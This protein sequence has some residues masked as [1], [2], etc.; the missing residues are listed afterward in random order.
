MRKEKLNYY[1][2]D[3]KAVKGMQE[4]ERYV[5]ASKIESSLIELVKIR[6][7]QINQCAYCTDMHTK[8]AREAGETEQ[9]IYGLSAW[10]ETPFYSKREQAALAWAEAL[11]RISEN[12]ITDDFFKEIREHFSEQEMVVLTTAIVAINGWNRLAIGFGNEAGTYKPELAK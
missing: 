10:S 2:I 1:E 3:Q 11:T 7:S 12:D 6:A 8:D 9:R 4:L 5:K